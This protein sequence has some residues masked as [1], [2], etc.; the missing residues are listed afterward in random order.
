[1]ADTDRNVKLE[2]SSFYG[3]GNPKVLFDWLHTVESFFRWY[4][5]SKEQLIKKKNLS[6]EQ[7]LF[8]VEAKLKGTSRI[9]SE[10]INK[11]VM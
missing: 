11:L 6:K 3:E 2:V 10:N 1:M 4:S 7:S 5:L 8:F 9:W